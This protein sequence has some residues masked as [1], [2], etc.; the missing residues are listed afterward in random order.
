MTKIQEEIVK[1]NSQNINQNMKLHTSIL[2]SILTSIALS[3]PSLASASEPNTQTNI[4]VS[5]NDTTQVFSKLGDKL[6]KGIAILASKA[7][8]ATDHFYPIFVRQQVTTGISQL[9]LMAV[10][11][12]MSV[13]LIR[14]GIANGKLDEGGDKSMF[15][16]FAG[17]VLGV[18]IFFN[19]MLLGSDTI[20]KICNPE[21]FAAQ[22][23]VQMIK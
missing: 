7:G 21:F 1:N 16:Y 17:T 6:E 2:A 11:V 12:I 8:V 4:F 13:L 18:I 19:I 10:G 23:I 14:M 20:G 3:L 5:I 22:T 15:G 9:L